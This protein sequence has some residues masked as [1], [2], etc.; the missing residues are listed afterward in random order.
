MNKQ[1][2]NKRTLQFQDQTTHQIKERLSNLKEQF[3]C[4]RMNYEFEYSAI[5]NEE[6]T[7][8]RSE[9]NHRKE[10]VKLKVTSA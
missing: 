10:L 6:I 4:A 1:N 7:D 3:K 5:L 8:L 9:L 2:V